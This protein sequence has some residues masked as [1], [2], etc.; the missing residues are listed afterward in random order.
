MMAAHE[1]IMSDVL[2]QILFNVWITTNEN[3][4][5]F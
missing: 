4:E 1:N 2:K 3:T 5:I